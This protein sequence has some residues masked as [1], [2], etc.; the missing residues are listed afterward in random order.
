MQ[1]TRYHLRRFL[2]E[3]T[4]QGHAGIKLDLKPSHFDPRDYKY[5]LIQPQV[6]MQSLPEETH[7]REH[8]PGREQKFD[9]GQFGICTMASATTGF[10]AFEAM[11]GSNYPVNGLS[12]RYGY[13]IEKNIDGD[14]HS[15]GS[16]LKICMQ[17]C[18]QYG[19]V[20]DDLYP[21]AE[22]TSDIDL[23]MP[24]DSLK[25]QAEPYKITTYAQLASVTDSDRSTLVQQICNAINQEGP[26]EAGIIVTENFFNVKG[27][28]WLVPFPSGRILGAHAIKLVDYNM[29]R[30]AILTWNTWG[31]RWAD[32]DEAWFPFDWFTRYA[33]IG[34]AIGRIW[35]LME[36]WTATKKIVP[37][38]ARRIEVTPGSDI[39][40]VDGQKIQMD[41]TAEIMND[42]LMAPLGAIGTNEGYLIERDGARA[43]LI[44][45]S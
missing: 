33:D 2:E 29:T 45:P 40:V 8:L 4:P 36:A 31:G 13:A 22:L 21:Y 28:D 39:L 5:S 17:V 6:G 3:E 9:Q 1:E 27:P 41:G 34:S 10:L 15:A 23:P 25:P 43:I 37:R 26:I 19:V 18:Q 14:P 11:L 16:T 38:A 44:R 30:K 42:R 32:N 20:P 7:N 35:Y 24:P 12:A